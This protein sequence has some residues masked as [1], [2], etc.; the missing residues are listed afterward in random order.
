MCMKIRNHKIYDCFPFYREL[1]LLELRLEELYDHVDHFVLVEADTTYTSRPK[2]FLFEEN[3]S[4]YTK[5][6]DKIIHVKV[7]DMPHHPD[8]WVNDR[9]QRDQIFRGIESADQNDL[10]LVSDLDE[11][12]RPE[13]IEQ[14]S[15][16]EQ[17]LFAV[18][19][20]LHNFKFNYMRVSP[21]PYQ[22]W[23]MAGR[24]HLF[25][26]IKPDAFRQLRFNFMNSPYQFSNN[27]CEVIEHGGW[28]FG[29]MGDKDWLLDKAKSFAH[30]EVN[31]PEFLAQIDPAESIKAKTSWARNSSDRY[32]IVEIDDY[33][34][35]A[36]INNLDKYQQY[37]LDN[38]VTKALALLPPY[39]YNN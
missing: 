22:I 37:I 33:F 6:L 25:N 14:M 13:A 17:S 1:D 23:G 8:A 27:G 39:P 21:D 34:P 31:T 5:Y 32:E 29:Y 36:L 19:M 10:I 3:K 24:R 30:T 12:F 11:I 26:D 38:P 4:R 15:N 35:K 18:R 2:P 7:E 20:S 28:H 9:F 16:S